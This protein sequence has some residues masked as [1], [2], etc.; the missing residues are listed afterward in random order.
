[1]LRLNLLL[2]IALILFAQT[3]LVGA[4][5]DL[6]ES[7]YISDD[8]TMLLQGDRPSSGLYDE[9]LLRTIELNFAQEDFWEQMTANYESEEN[10]LADLVIDGKNYL[11]VGVRF[12]GMTSYSRIGNSQKKS[13]NIELD[14]T[15]DD[16]RLMGYKTLN[17][18]NAASDP[19]FMREILYFDAVRRYTVGSKASFVKLL[20][21]GENWGVYVHVQQLNADLIEEW[22]PDN[23]GIRWKAGMNNG[24][25]GGTIPGGQQPPGGTVQL[26]RTYEEWIASDFA[27]DLNGDGQ[28][29]R[30]DYQIFLNRQNDPNR[31][32]PG[33][34]QQ[35][36]TGGLL[37]PP[38]FEEWLA[39]DQATDM[40]DDSE[41]T[42]D[43]YQ[44]FLESQ[45]LPPGAPPPAGKLQQLPPGGQRPGGA[46]GGGMFPGGDTALIWLGED[47]TVYETAYELKSSGAD[48]AW[49]PLIAACDVLNNTPLDQLADAA[50]AAMAVDRWL[51]FLAVE[52]IFTDQDSYLT[53]GADYQLYGESETGRVHPL[54][55]DGNES[56]STRS[57]NLSPFEGEDN[58]DRPA[59]SRLLSVPVLR[60]RYLAHMRTIVEESFDWNIFAPRI[61]A[62]RALIETEV[63]ADPQKLYTHAEFITG[64]SEL[65]TFVNARREY[66]LTHPEIAQQAPDILSVERTH[67]TASTAGKL[68]QSE[69]PSGA[70]RVTA[71]IGGQVPADQ[72]QLHYATGI[73]G[74]FTSLP[75]FDDG[76]HEDGAAT[77]G[78]FAAEIPSLPAGS[79]VRYYVEARAADGTAAFSPPGAEHDV[80][81]YQV[82]ARVAA[83]T[84]VVINELMAD[85]DGG[86]QDP[87]GDYDDWVELHNISLREIDLSGNYLTDREND[88][89]KWAFPE[90]TILLPGAYLVVWI[91]DD[92]GD[93]SGLH[94]NFKL[95]ND[96]EEIFLVDT[97]ERDNAILDHVLFEAQE[98]DISYGRSPDG[99]GPFAS[100]NWPTPAASNLVSTDVSIAAT[101]ALPERFSLE[102]NY[103]NPFNSGTVIRFALPTVGDVELAIF[104]LVG[105]KVAVLAAGEYLPGA[106][107]LHWDGHSNAGDELATGVYLYRLQAGS[108]VQTRRLLLLR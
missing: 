26:P 45:P 9:T 98:T 100:L 6:P 1:M 53:K 79:L 15:D 55:H 8:G 34:G 19:T 90:G 106:Y 49:S 82:A 54:E 104:N 37:P 103:P 60:Q 18:N 14:F 29:T 99:I 80:F 68:A 56:F 27:R 70:V 95:S 81:T 38:T 20:I 33:E 57:T 94:A 11:D 39:S 52:N 28:I 50:E 63:E 51:W 4:E 88:L 65:E 46:G 83:S 5:T 21:N 59:I 48:D 25:G 40:N 16:Q 86:V 13:F 91:D 35:L 108:Q 30:A 89:R 93:E 61:A 22:F 84:S 12:K 73:T 47:P 36:P 62:H 64:L 2:P 7:M 67:I 31:P 44:L 107:E 85:N 105:Q 17:L 23:D 92:D 71:K 66:L 69:F 97:D 58:A 32:P 87:Q 10:I 72:L 102:P 74:P 3:T 77:D 41:I 101:D 75:M 24:G 96:G 42:E 78:L 43:D 76:E